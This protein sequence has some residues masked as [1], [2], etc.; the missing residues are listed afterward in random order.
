MQD[1]L[2]AAKQALAAAVKQQKQVRLLQ[3]ERMHL[4]S[5]LNATADAERETIILGKLVH[6]VR[7]GFTPGSNTTYT[8]K[9]PSMYTALHMCSYTPML[10]YA[11]NISCQCSADMHRYSQHWL[12]RDMPHGIISLADAKRPASQHFKTS[13]LVAKHA[14]YHCRC[15]CFQILL[16]C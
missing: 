1:E 4:Q 9:A 6:A 15:A 3:Q 14:M 13:H 10:S 8:C 16:E 7:S 2:T 5:S 11:V 12:A